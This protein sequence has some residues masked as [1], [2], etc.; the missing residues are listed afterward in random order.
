[1]RIKELFTKFERSFD[2]DVHEVE[3]EFN[4]SLEDDCIYI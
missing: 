4:K 1:M 2:G 3:N